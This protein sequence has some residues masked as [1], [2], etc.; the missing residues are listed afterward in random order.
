M[1]PHATGRS[2]GGAGGNR[3]GCVPATAAVRKVR[4]DAGG[5]PRG[6]RG[7][8]GEV[9]VHRSVVESTLQVSRRS[10]LSLP[11]ALSPCHGGISGGAPGGA[12][13]ARAHGAAVSATLARAGAAGVAA[14]ATSQRARGS[15]MAGVD[16]ARTPPAP[17]G[18]GRCGGGGRQPEDW[19]RGTRGGEAESS[20]SGFA[21]IHDRPG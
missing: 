1:L 6:G 19:R 11:D 17:G 20:M 12:T 14:S 15:G 8:T 5:R 2:H 7:S 13:P 18:G 10:S 9:A 3:Q 16:G 21:R 4:G